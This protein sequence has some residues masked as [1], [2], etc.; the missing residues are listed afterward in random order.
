MP[1]AKLKRKTNS[2]AA[3]ARRSIFAQEYA[4]DRNGTRAA[5]RAGYSEKSATMQA[6]RLLTNAKVRAQVDAIAAAAA[7]ANQ[8]TVER[9]MREIARVA[10]SD[11]RRLFDQDGKLK[12]LHEL[13]DEA[14]AQI[15]G[16]ETSHVQLRKGSDQQELFDSEDGAGAAL[17]ITKIKR[18]DKNRA[19][20]QCMAILGM[21]KSIDP[22]AAGGLNLSINLSGGKRVR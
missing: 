5:I 6:S 22:N 13:D 16:V 2:E 9:T 21:H 10:Y 14:A 4:K 15:A 18:W 12:P 8:I 20:D 11:V 3:E 17:V 1:K 7:A 19:L